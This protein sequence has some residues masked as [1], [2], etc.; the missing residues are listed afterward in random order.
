MSARPSSSDV[1]IDRGESASADAARV[2]LGGTAGLRGV[3]EP[4][5]VAVVADEGAD[6]RLPFEQ[7]LP[8]A[9]RE[10]VE[11]LGLRGPRANPSLGSTGAPA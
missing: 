11:L 8:G 10:V 6:K 4:V 9:G 7:A 2:L 1:A 3:G 5:V